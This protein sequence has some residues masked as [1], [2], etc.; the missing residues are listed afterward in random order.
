LKTFLAGNPVHKRIPHFTT[1]YFHYLPLIKRFEA[2]F[3]KDRVKVTLFEEFKQDRDAVLDEV[4]RFAGLKHDPAIGKG[5]GKRNTSFSDRS[6]RVLRLL[7]GIFVHPA[8]HHH[9][10]PLIRLPGEFWLRRLLRA[11]DAVFPARRK[12]IRPKVKAVLGDR[13]AAS[14]REL[15]QHLGKDLSKW[16]Y[17]VE[18]A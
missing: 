7:N 13:F 15:G 8:S 1:G 16:D 3:G 4:G 18:D 11:T 9:Y 17:V 5:T 14:N 12:T 6:I 2:R 10:R